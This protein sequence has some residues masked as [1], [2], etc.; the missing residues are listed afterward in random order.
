MADPIPQLRQGDMPEMKG[1]FWHMV[2]PGAI[3]VG[4]AVGSGELVLWPWITARFGLIMAWAPLLAV[5]FQCWFNIEIGRWAIATG[6]SA[7]N[8][9]ARASM[10]FIYL[11]I[12]F[13]VI[14]TMLPGWG[15]LTAAT[16]R[17]LL[18]P[19]GGFWSEGSV[20]A[21]D[22]LW[23]LPVTVAVWLVLLGSKKIYSGV[24]RTVMVM[25]LII[26]VGMVLVAV[27][28]GTV[29]DVGRLGS[30]IF[31]FPPIIHLDNDFDFLR[32]FGA[33]VFAGNGGFGILFYSYYLRDK[34]IGMGQRFPMLEVD[35]KGKEIQ[36]DETGY[37]YEDNP[38]NAQR[39]RAW[40]R[41][42]NQDIIW[43]FGATTVVTLFLFMFASFVV[44]YPQ[45]LG[46]GDSDLIWKLSSIL[47]SVM[48]TWGRY[49]F[50]IIGIAALFST[51]L[52]NTDGGVRMWTDMIHKAFKS[53]RKWTAGQMVVPI[54][55]ITWPIGFF[56]LWF[57]E[58]QGVTVL[59][60]FF[61]SASI[62]GIVMTIIIPTILYMNLKVL[63]RSARPGPLSVTFTL[64]GTLFYAAFSV[65][66]IW[67]K[68]VALV[69]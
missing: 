44:L 41:Y 18:F 2:G 65:Y 66:L 19:E 58:T 49:L 46:F 31:T 29:E 40:K 26:I 37:L 47:G 48:G 64:M 45:P 54:L 34:G 43:L 33:L 15:R 56:S 55:F 32:F 14:L 10:G 62:N 42:L 39:F 25:V 7:M 27:R 11:F 1:S 30:G 13:L 21:T 63:P 59:D 67:D 28:I 61:I 69:A 52:A 68:L 8:G 36:E 17:F 51:I 23:T 16:L 24:E 6:E 50:L 20:W 3:M 57:F 35:M 12:F 9:V 60:F 22:W 4:L 38:L 5:F 53:S